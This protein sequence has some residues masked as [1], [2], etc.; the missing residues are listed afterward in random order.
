MAGNGR[1]CWSRRNYAADVAQPVRAAAAISK[2]LRSR[3]HVGGSNGVTAVDCQRPGLN[4]ATS[5]LRLAGGARPHR[6]TRSRIKAPPGLAFPRRAPR[7][8][9]YVDVA[10]VDERRRERR[11]FAAKCPGKAVQ[12]IA[13]AFSQS[14]RPQTASR[15]SGESKPRFW[16]RPPP[17]GACRSHPSAEL[18]AGTRSATCPRCPSRSSMNPRADIGELCGIRQRDYSGGRSSHQ[19]PPRPR[20][21]MA[22]GAGNGCG[23][24]MLQ[25][26]PMAG[27]LSTRY[28]A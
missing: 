1:R 9:A 25:S 16:A 26:V 24:V 6:R 15:R 22:D 3:R 17:S 10:M 7:P 8:P 5:G 13:G 28:H 14:G 18:R 2:D 12:R 11:A 21:E 20:K 23:P 27:A 4:S 19:D